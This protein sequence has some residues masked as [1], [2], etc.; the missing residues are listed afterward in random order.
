MNG[1]AAVLGQMVGGAD[2][3]TVLAGEGNTEWQT[4]HCSKDALTDLFG[5][6]LQG[7]LATLAFTCLIG[8]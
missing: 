5:W 7:I 2:P 3:G 4:L 8:E 6:F 1:S